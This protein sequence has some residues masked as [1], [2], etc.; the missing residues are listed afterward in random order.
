MR[1]ERPDLHAG[2]VMIFTGNSFFD[3]VIRLKR[4][5]F[6]CHVEIYIGNGMSVASRNWPQG[7]N[8]YPVR[9]DGLYRV[10]RP[11]G[12]FNLSKMTHWFYSK[13]PNGE[14]SPCGQKYDVFGLLCFSFARLQGSKTKM[15]CSEFARKAL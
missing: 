6:A 2:D 10:Y 1:P 13:G 11:K 4:G 12:T 8:R 7:V 5:T 9:W 14:P 15:F 3:W